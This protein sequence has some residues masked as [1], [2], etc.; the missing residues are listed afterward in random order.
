MQ[1]ILGVMINVVKVINVSSLTDTGLKF[2]MYYSTRVCDLEVNGM[3]LEIFKTNSI[4]PV[5]FFFF[6]AK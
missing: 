5:F 1:L 4:V 6:F 3:D 2:H